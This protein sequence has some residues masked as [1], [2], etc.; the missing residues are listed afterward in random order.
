MGLIFQNIKKVTKQVLRNSSN[1]I[2]LAG[3]DTFLFRGSNLIV[4]FDLNDVLWQ[5]RGQ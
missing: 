5:M 4:V 2:T 1:E 3:D